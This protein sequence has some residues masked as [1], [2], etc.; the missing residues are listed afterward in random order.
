MVNLLVFDI[1][2]QLP[3]Y[4]DGDIKITQSNAVSDNIIIKLYGLIQMSTDKRDLRV[5]KLI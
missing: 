2:W 3:Y 4:I 5:V 1:H